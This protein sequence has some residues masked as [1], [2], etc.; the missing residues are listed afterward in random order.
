[1]NIKTSC[2]CPPIPTRRFDWA[3]YDEDTYDA[4]FDYELGRYVSSSIVGHGETE[5]ESIIEFVRDTLWHFDVDIR[6]AWSRKEKLAVQQEQIAKL[7]ELEPGDGL[8]I[9]RSHL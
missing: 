5:E 9:E 8:G 2:V 4:D 6:D 3:C 1:M 7:A